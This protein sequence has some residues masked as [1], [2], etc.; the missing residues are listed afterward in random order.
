MEKLYIMIIIIIIISISIIAIYSEQKSEY[1]DPDMVNMS[2]KWRNDYTGK[3]TLETK[4]N[5]PLLPPGGQKYDL[6]GLPLYNRPL[7]DCW[8]DDYKNCY[9]SNKL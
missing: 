4:N 9:G 8:Y 7:Y 6:R 2:A 3:Y 5:Q 1:F